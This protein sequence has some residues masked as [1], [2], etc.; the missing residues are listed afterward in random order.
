MTEISSV[1]YAVVIVSAVIV[2]GLDLA[3]FLKFYG[4][5]NPKWPLS[6][7]V[8]AWKAWRRKRAIHL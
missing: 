5:Y 1:Q 8:M 6:G 4:A 2:N 7:Y 3:L